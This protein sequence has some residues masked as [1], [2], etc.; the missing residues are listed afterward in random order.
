MLA[1]YIA[2]GSYLI[3]YNWWNI[4]CFT[5]CHVFLTSFLN[6]RVCLTAGAIDSRSVFD[7]FDTNIWEEHMRFLDVYLVAKLFKC[8]P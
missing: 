1:L 5:S 3:V 2:R 7:A 8:G 4:C 6:I